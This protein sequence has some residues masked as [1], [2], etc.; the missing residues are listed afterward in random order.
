MFTKRIS[1]I[2]TI[3]PAA[4]RRITRFVAG[5]AGAHVDQHLA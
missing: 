1:F 3:P 2:A 5:R 4:W